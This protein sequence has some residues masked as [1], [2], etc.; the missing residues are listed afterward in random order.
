MNWTHVLHVLM[1]AYY[2]IHGNS[3]L[4]HYYLRHHA[5]GFLRSGYTSE[6]PATRTAARHLLWWL[7]TNHRAPVDW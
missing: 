2:T 5:V 4:Y 6:S 7:V 3:A 1:H